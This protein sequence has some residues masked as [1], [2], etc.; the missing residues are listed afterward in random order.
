VRFD[1]SLLVEAFSATFTV[2][3]ARVLVVFGY[4]I[5]AAWRYQGLGFL[6]GM[7]VINK[8]QL[9]TVARSLMSG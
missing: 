8:S 2:L 6:L 4:L 5:H 3:L 9:K 1:N 7:T